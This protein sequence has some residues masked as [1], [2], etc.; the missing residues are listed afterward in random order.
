MHLTYNQGGKHVIHKN[1]LAEFYYPICPK[2]E[3]QK[4]ETMITYFG[5]RHVFRNNVWC[6]I[7]KW[8]QIYEHLHLLRANIDLI[9]GETLTWH[10]LCK[11]SNIISEANTL[12]V[13]LTEIE[14]SDVTRQITWKIDVMQDTFLSQPGPENDSVSNLTTCA[15][16]SPEIHPSPCITWDRIKLKVWFCFEKNK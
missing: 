13:S 15:R 8:L 10:W 6:W 12:Q 1:I 7:H 9:D 2:I 4:V 11:I 5:E 14:T 16:K 3:L